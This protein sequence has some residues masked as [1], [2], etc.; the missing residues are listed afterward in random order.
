VRVAFEVRRFQADQLEQLAHTGAP[1]VAGAEFVNDERLLDD[2][3]DPHA[4]VE[5][6]VGILEDDLHVAARAAHALARRRRARPR[7]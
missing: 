2:V 5:R 7:P 1:F 3:A 4:R 6:R